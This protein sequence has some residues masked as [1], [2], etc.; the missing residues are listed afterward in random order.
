[1]LLVLLVVMYLIALRV[2]N[3]QQARIFKILA[4]QNL[5]SQ[6]SL[7][8]A[9]ELTDEHFDSLRREIQLQK[10]PKAQFEEDDD[11][12]SRLKAQVDTG[13]LLRNHTT[14]KVTLSSRRAPNFMYKV[15]ILIGFFQI[16]SYLPSLG[17][18]PWPTAFVD[19]IKAFTFFNFDFIP[20]RKSVV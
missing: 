19:F 17:D 12:D 13:M 5:E 1:M 15:K 3:A 14:P 20:D 10:N 18:I 16:S 9:L 6:E 11:S 8:K 4:Q 2:A 7:R